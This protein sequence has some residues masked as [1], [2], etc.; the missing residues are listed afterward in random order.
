MMRDVRTENT[1][2]KVVAQSLPS[3]HDDSGFVLED[4]GNGLVRTVGVARGSLAKASCLAGLPFPPHQFHTSETHGAAPCSPRFRV[5]TN[6]GC[7]FHK[8]SERARRLDSRGKGQA[9]LDEQ[10]RRSS[11]PAQPSNMFSQSLAGLTQAAK[12][13]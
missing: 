6:R 2:V 9:A 5:S 11:P 10:G 12:K 3:R 4:P 13:C 7:R 8:L 1:F